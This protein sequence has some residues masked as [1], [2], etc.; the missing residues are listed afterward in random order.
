M[1]P[2]RWLTLALLLIGVPAVPSDATVATIATTA[3]LEDHEE[4]SVT[5][6]LRAAFKAAVAGAAAM[7]LPWVQI[8]QALVLDD[9]VAVQIVATDEDPGLNTGEAT[10]GPE[11]GAD[12][13]GHEPT[14][15]KI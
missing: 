9:A 1:R 2:F 4:Q 5:A 8:R 3:P 6:A 15:G 10:P 11:S 13:E 14:E 12:A 7:G